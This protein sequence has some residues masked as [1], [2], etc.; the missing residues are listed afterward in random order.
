ML[1][2]TTLLFQICLILFTSRCLG[3]IFRKLNQPQV[4]GEMI[5]G[6][7]LGPSLLGWL[8]P[9]ISSALFPPESLNYLRACLR[10]EINRHSG[11]FPDKKLAKHTCHEQ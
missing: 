9:P 8:S 11:R 2:L 1:N 7:M 10:I 6:I 4:I 5:A 3:W